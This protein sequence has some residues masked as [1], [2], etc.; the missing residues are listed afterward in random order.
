MNKCNHRGLYKREAEELQPEGEGIM[1]TEEGFAELGPSPLRSS[2]RGHKP[3]NM[4]G[5]QRLERQG[6]GLSLKLFQEKHGPLGT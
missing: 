4:G 6:S 5:H 1:M 3:K 2:G